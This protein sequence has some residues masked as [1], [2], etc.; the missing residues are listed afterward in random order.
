MR[1]IH[2]PPTL[3]WDQLRDDQIAQL[4][5]ASTSAV[6]KYRHAHRLPKAPRKPGS[7]AP[8]KIRPALIRWSYSVKWNAKNQG[9]S[10]NHMAVVMRQLRADRQSA[11]T[12]T[13]HRYPDWV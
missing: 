2:F 8:P 13:I 3:Q 11:P 1:P 9:V 10:Y 7:G 12:T 5:G 6:S 4:V